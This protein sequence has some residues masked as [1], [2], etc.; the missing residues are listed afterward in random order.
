ML[1]KFGTNCLESKFLDTHWL[2]NKHSPAFE[3]KH[4]ILHDLDKS[5]I[6]LDKFQSAFDF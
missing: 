3:I 6:Y 4:N 2:Q 1:L 5:E